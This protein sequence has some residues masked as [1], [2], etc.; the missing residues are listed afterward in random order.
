MTGWKPSRFNLA[1][2]AQVGFPLA[3]AHART[4]CAGCHSLERRDLPPP[5][6]A[7]TLGAAKFAFKLREKECAQCHHDPHAGRFVARGV[8]AK[9]DGCRACHDAESWRP[10]QVTVAEH[11]G[12]GFALEAA[13]RAVPCTGCH[14]ELKARPE[15]SSL[16]LAAHPRPLAFDQD[17]RRCEDCHADVHQG[18][19]A[20]RRDRGACEACHDSEIWRPATRFVHDRDS[21]FKLAGAHATVACAACHTIVKGT[22]NRATTRYRGV[23][24]E[25][26]SC[27]APAGRPN[28]GKG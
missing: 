12:F 9:P 5:A 28:G 24:V 20:A 26:A 8:R 17:R 7:A 23:P 19:F 15:V 6:A 25:C 14:A 27:H 11:A 4:P 21:R 10:A 3:G 1:D 22:R 13:H 2:H 16:A 18:Q